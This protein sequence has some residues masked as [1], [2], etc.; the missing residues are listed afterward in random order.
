M[1]NRRNNR[2]GLGIIAL[3][4]L[5]LL[6]MLRGAVVR[7][8]VFERVR[9]SEVATD[10][11]RAENEF[12]FDHQRGDMRGHRGRGGFGLLGGLI[13]LATFGA[14]G[15]L[16]F[17]WLQ[18]RRGGGSADNIE[19]DIRVGDEIDDSPTA[20]VDPEE[21]SVDDLV[22]AMKRLGIKKLEL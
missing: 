2:L 5:L 8:Q 3:G 21:M 6:P 9:T 1:K 16:L 18:R 11:E 17:R 4:L 13:K 20:T 10:T 19:D 12:R 14:I 7:R 15:L 22:A